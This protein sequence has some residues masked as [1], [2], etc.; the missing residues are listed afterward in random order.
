MRQMDDHA[1]TVVLLIESELK[2][3]G[4]M[5][6]SY[7]STKFGNNSLDVFEEIYYEQRC[8]RIATGYDRL[9]YRHFS[10]G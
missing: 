1:T 10:K 5:V 9:H 8:F 4:D 2:K 7:L 6:G 3:Y